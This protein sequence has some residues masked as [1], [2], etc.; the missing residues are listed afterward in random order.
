MSTATVGVSL[1]AHGG[2]ITAEAAGI[3]VLADELSRVP[4]AIRISR[5]SMRIARQSLRLGLGLS[6]VAM[7][8]AF[9]GLIPPPVGALLQELIDVASILNALRASRGEAAPPL[10]T[11]P[12]REVTPLT[13]GARR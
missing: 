9:W 2:G 1:A 7:L 12:P 3:V 5:R 4:D 8:F 6:A 11:P 10:L 13:A